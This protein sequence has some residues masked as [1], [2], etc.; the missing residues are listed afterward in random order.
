MVNEVFAALNARKVA[1]EEAG[2][3]IY[4]LSVG[5]PDFAPYDHVVD[6]LVDAA[7]DPQMWKYSL[8]D[9]PEMKQAVC[10][11]YKR[12]F[13]VDGIT[14]DMV[15]SVN[16]TQEGVGH[17]ALAL[18]DPGD[19]VLVP[20]PCYP[21]FRGGR[22]ARR[23]RVSRIIRLMPSTISCPTSPASIRSSPTAPST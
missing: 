2:R 5:T 22:Q 11:Y 18:L 7:R 8:R 3:T 6:A 21:V 17:F 13:D 20:D 9:L 12:R 16:G 10:D 23:R 4:N 14:P 15:C 19:V 1:L